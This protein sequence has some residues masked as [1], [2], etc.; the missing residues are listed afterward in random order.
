M[1]D[2]VVKLLP[3]LLSITY[4]AGDVLLRHYNGAGLTIDHKTD[5]SPVTVA[6]E[7]ADA[8]IVRQLT[9]IIP[10]VP[11]VSEE[12]YAM[13]ARV[14][15]RG[16]HWLVDP[17]DG[18]KEFIKRNGHFTVNIAFIHQSRP[19][20]GIVAAPALDIL[21]AGAEGKGAWV[22]LK[23]SDLQPIKVRQ[24]PVEG[25]TAVV[26]R[27][28]NEGQELDRFL[29]KFK[30]AKQVSAGSSLKFGLVAVG[31]ADIY[32][33]LGRTMEW[34]T[35]A[36][37]AVLRAAGGYVEKI[38]D[39]TALQYGKPDLANPHFVAWGEKL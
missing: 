32:P 2:T 19:I 16:D 39:G 30:I 38:T 35:A 34:D 33:R 22:S 1:I 18:T 14:D 36:G 10:H 9:Q 26:S 25:L 31:E 12:S 29:E 28:H 11:V 3:Q 21:Y 27:S 15:R 13:G 23:K 24:R 37:D 5:G 20:L 7:E 6:D 17:L 4:E 8:L